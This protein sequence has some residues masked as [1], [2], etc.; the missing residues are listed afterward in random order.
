[1]SSSLFRLLNS[2]FGPGHELVALDTHVVMEQEVIRSPSRVHQLGEE[3]HAQKVSQT[4]NQGTVPVSNAIRRNKLLTFG[5]R[6]DLSKKGNKMSGIQKNTT[7]S[8]STLK[9]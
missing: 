6:T 7:L 2:L 8:V 5:N 1:M 9:T 3:L 4:I